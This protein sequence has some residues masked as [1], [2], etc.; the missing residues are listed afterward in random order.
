M[1]AEEPEYSV[2]EKTEAF[3]KG[4]AAVGEFAQKVVIPI[5]RGQLKKSEK[6]TAITGTYFRMY[7]WVQ[8]LIRLND[9]LHFQA[10]ATVARALFE[11]LLDIKLLDADTNGKLVAKFHAFPEVE[12]F[13]MAK[14]YVKFSDQNPDVPTRDEYQRA[15][16]SKPG[17]QQEI[18][19]KIVKHWGKTKGG[20]PKSPKH[21]S[22]MNIR[23]R[24]L[25]F[26]AS[27]EEKY[28]YGYRIGCLSSHSGSGIYADLDADA[29]ESIFC[30]SHVLSQDFF[31]EATKICAKVMEIS[32][33]VGE[34]SEMV[35][36]LELM[37][38]RVLLDIQISKIEQA[39]SKSR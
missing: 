13:Q 33:A 4:T 18:R 14:E 24:T 9:P 31:L 16:I 15:L 38:D 11:L 32:K 36:E 28:L 27:Y 2:R 35:K 37:P 8:S 1:L 34:F 5:L 10:A 17:K 23:E 6:E 12:R 20:K 25:K 3:Y 21:W 7:A 26:G 22:G 30:L 39:Q 19:D 29:L